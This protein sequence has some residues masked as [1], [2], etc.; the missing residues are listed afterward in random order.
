M[1]LAVVVAAQ[2]S[3]RRLSLSGSTKNPFPAKSLPHFAGHHG[4]G[5]GAMKRIKSHYSKNC[6]RLM[7]MLVEMTADSSADSSLLMCKFLIEHTPDSSSIGTAFGMCWNG[8][9]LCSLS[10]SLIRL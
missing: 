7:E 9:R 3:S 2:K 8:I 4:P 6:L 10:R 5:Q 1:F